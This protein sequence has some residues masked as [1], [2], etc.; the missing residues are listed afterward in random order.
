MMRKSKRPTIGKFQGKR[1][2]Q[3]LVVGETFGVWTTST[4]QA[5][6]IPFFPIQQKK[7][8]LQVD[9]RDGEDIILSR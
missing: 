6:G 8:P 2:H 3:D 1:S 5:P 4:K 7:K 9:D